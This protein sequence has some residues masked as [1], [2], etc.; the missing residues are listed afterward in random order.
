MSD[1][2]EDLSSIISYQNELYNDFD[3][4]KNKN[5]KLESDNSKLLFE[6]NKLRKIVENQE[7]ITELIKKEYEEKIQKLNDVID[8]KNKNI[9]F[10]LL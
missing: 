2:N 7:Q 9:E 5:T 1:N 6:I 4:E 3:V 10:M 8:K